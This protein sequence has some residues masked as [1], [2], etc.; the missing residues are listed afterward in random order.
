MTGSIGDTAVYVLAWVVALVARD[1]DPPQERAGR[2]LARS[3]SSDQPQPPAGT[4][5]ARS[6]G[7]GISGAEVDD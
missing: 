7:G 1:S 4:S 3:E 6:P 2:G 5:G